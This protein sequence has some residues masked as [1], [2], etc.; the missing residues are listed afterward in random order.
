MTCMERDAAPGREETQQL[1]GASAAEELREL[2]A[3][4]TLFP[5]ELLRRAT[6]GAVIGRRLP[7]GPISPSGNA[8][9]AD[10]NTSR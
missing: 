4:A 10:R 5:L 1:P 6:A 8:D 3:A 9:P 7:A 2:L